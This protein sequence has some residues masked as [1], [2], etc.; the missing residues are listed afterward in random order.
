V[1]EL[2]PKIFPRLSFV[3][4]RRDKGQVRRAQNQRSVIDWPPRLATPQGGK[5]RPE[6]QGNAPVAASDQKEREE[7][8]GVHGGGRMDR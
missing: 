6:E 1:V 8:G 2:W 4:E 7:K 3:V 5:G